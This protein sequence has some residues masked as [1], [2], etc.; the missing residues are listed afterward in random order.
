[1]QD[2]KGQVKYV[3]GSS[4]LDSIPVTF[5]YADLAFRLTEKVNGAV[6][7]KYLPPDDQLDE[8]N[9]IGIWDDGDVQV[10][11]PDRRPYWIGTAWAD[12]SSPAGTTVAL[13]LCHPVSCVLSF[14]LLCKPG[15]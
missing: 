6:S 12:S 2:A 11:S 1:M 10:C 3:G 9:L 8:D 15:A 5:K 14:C 7:I 4:H 13:S